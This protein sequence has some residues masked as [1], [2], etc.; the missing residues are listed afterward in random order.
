[1]TTTNSEPSNI[2]FIDEGREEVANRLESLAQ[3]V[4]SGRVHCFAY[5]YQKHEDVRTGWWW[6]QPGTSI[7]PLVGGLE[8][9]K[10]DLQMMAY[11]IH[12]S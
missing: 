1:M 12:D 3:Q 7:Y 4:R 5:C 8:S 2:H 10:T 11:R 6:G 9:C